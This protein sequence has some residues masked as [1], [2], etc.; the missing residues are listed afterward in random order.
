MQFQKGPVVNIQINWGDCNKQVASFFR[1][2]WT[3]GYLYS[4]QEFMEL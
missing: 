4:P 3:R 1:T 2:N